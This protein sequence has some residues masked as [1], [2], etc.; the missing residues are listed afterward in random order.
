MQVFNRIGLV[1][2]V[3]N[4]QV[5]DSLRLVERF[6][7]KHGREVYIES[8][9][10]AMLGASSSIPKT[11]DELGNCCDLVIAVGGDGNILS[12]ARKMAPFGVPI[13]GVNRGK[14][15]FLADVSPDDI[16][17]IQN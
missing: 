13:L 5:G 8:S 16:E 14:L 12:C 7:L 9:A 17:F 15:G 3:V 4:E 11:M 1:A 6:L 2:R 10:A